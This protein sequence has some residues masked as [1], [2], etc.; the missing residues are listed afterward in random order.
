MKLRV[1]LLVAIGVLSAALFFI[2]VRSNAPIQQTPS[3]SSELKEHPSPLTNAEEKDLAWRV[4]AALRWI[5]TW[6]KE[7]WGCQTDNGTE[8][9]DLRKIYER[10]AGQEIQM[11]VDR[12]EDGVSVCLDAL[13]IQLG[14]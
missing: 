11:A 8:A 14:F 5:L 10:H 4:R 6:Q 1:L 7:P 9:L 2:S 13:H 12:S 3:Q